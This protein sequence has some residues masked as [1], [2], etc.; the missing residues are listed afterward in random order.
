M[1]KDKR[2]MKKYSETI[3]PILSQFKVTAA[4]YVEQ[5]YK[6]AWDIDGQYILKRNSNSC[7]I[8]KSV[9]VNCFLNLKGLP[10]A[11]YH[12]AVDGSFYVESNGGFYSLMTKLPNEEINPY[13]GDDAFAA[14]IGKQLGKAAAD[15]HL[16]LNEFKP[17]QKWDDVDLTAELHDW[18]IPEF[19]CKRIVF[20]KGVLEM[21]LKF[22]SLYHSLPRQLIHRDMHI[23]NL[24]FHKG[25][26]C[27]YTD[28]DVGQKNTRLFD[29]CYLGCSLLVEHYKTEKDL[30]LW[31]IIFRSIIHEYDRI[32]PL[33][34]EEK[35]AIPVLFVFIEML[36]AAFFSKIGQS[37]ISQSCVDM[38]NWLYEHQNFISQSFSN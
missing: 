15:L 12:K 17:V 33:T 16:A 28:F 5:I 7:E 22:D 19:A 24:L 14:K 20:D 2:V 29:L 21:C 4:E 23:S 31:K 26:F 37:A 34:N 32:L 35:K 18:M 27:G 10:V 9:E 36:F 25:C 30:S 3:D 13:Q 6:S 8:E 1:N 38:T 11:C